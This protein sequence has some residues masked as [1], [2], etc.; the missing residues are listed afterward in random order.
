MERKFIKLSNGAK[1]K[2]HAQPKL[3]DTGHARGR[4]LQTEKKV[5]KYTK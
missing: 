2:N 1:V 3:L 4:K 5:L